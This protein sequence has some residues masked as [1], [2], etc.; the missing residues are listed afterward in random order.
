M[1][2]NIVT[3]IDGELRV[4]SEV[5]AERTE[6]QHASVLRLI[7]DNQVAFEEFGDLG[8][9]ILDRPGVPGPPLQIAL[10]NEPQSTLLMTFL[11]NSEIVVKFKVELVKQFYAMRQALTPAPHQRAEVLSVKEQSQ[12]LRTLRTSL[13]PDYADAKARIL[14]ARSMGEEPMIDEAKRPLDVQGY[15]ESRGVPK[16]ILRSRRSTFGTAVAKIYRALYSDDPKMVDRMINGAPKQ[17][18]GYTEEHRHMFDAAFAN[19][20]VLSTLNNNE[21]DLGDI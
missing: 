9:E 15:L 16:A 11:R 19:D 8:F 2:N 6:N 20:R 7:R 13:Q 10:L 3:Q 17:V 18:K 12:I 4:S 21:L 14:L 5:I 1:S